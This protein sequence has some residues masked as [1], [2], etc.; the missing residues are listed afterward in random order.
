MNEQIT[1]DSLGSITAAWLHA[2]IAMSKDGGHSYEYRDGQH[3]VDGI[4]SCASFAAAREL[5]AEVA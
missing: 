4:V 5:M 2:D 3:I 1:R